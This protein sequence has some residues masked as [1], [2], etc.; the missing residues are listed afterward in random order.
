[1]AD[2]QAG[3]GPFLGVLLLGRGRIGAVSTLGGIAGMIAAAPAG[4]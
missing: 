2:M 1:M 4:G 3:I